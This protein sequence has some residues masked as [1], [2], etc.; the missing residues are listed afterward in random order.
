MLKLH[1]K[2]QRQA[3]TWLVES[4]MTIGSDAKN[5]IVIKDDKI[6]PQHVEIRKDGEALY[7]SD[8][9]SYS[10]TKVNGAVVKQHFQLRAGDVISLA[11]V[12]L[13]VQDSKTANDAPKSRSS[14]SEWSI[15]ALAGELKGKS[16]P[17]H[18]SVVLG[19]SSSCDVVV[20]DAHMSRRHAEINLKGGVARIV[21]LQSSNGT[22]VNGEKV[23][24]KVLKHGDKISFDHLT[25]LV[26]GPSAPV[27][28]AEDDDDD[29]A[30]VFR[31]A[32]IPRQPAAAPKPTVQPVSAGLDS[33]PVSGANEPKSIMPWVLLSVV[34]VIAVA[35]G[36]GVMVL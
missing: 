11:G 29:E 23:G 12:E 36:V 1:F 32:P 4:V 3:D 22:C 27:V 5:H 30:T 25:F 26:A 33:V 35:V 18:G 19:R 24:E 15:M 8:L 17:I 21:D 20:Q 9:N 14:R 34:V 28:E 31:A 2:D 6:D 7:L 13:E 10:G 16:I